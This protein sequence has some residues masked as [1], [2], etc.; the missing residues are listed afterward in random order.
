MNKNFYF[1]V[2]VVRRHVTKSRIFLVRFYVCLRLIF[3]LS[4]VCLK[5]LI[6]RQ[7]TYD[8]M[9]GH[10]QIIQFKC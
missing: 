9:K 7:K 10:T 6:I 2:V 3:V 8:K 1:W 4:S 5:C